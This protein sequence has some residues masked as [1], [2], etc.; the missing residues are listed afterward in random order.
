MGHG[1]QGREGGMSQGELI[2]ERRTVLSL[3]DRTGSWSRPY[4]EA[5]YRVVT[6]DM[7]PAA[8]AHPNREHWQRSVRLLERPSF[9]V[10]GILA[11]PPCTMFANSGARWER[12][13]E[14]MNEAVAVV[15][16]CLRLVAV[17]APDWWALENPNGKLVRWLGP[18]AYRFHP[19]D[20]VGWPEGAADRYTKQTCL[21]GQFSPPEKRPG[22]PTDGSKLWRLP[23]S[24]E[25][26]NLRSVTPAGFARAFFEANP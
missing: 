3:C 24:P 5:G 1:A 10:H 23:P 4:A 11:A 13:E 9:R 14:E 25:R 17:C 8:E 7:Q 20:F 22:N 16:A 21:W 18:P 26:A 15:D 19:S 2:S 6:V 12:T